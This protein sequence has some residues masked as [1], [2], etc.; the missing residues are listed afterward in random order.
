MGEFELYCRI[1]SDDFKCKDQTVLYERKSGQRATIEGKGIDKYELYRFDAEEGKDF[2]P[3]FNNRHNRAGEALEKLRA[4]CDYIIL[5]SCKGNLYIMLVEMKSGKENASQQLVASH[6]FMEYVKNS[7]LRIKDVN[8]YH[9]FDVN[10]IKEKQL[11]LKKGPKIKNRPTTQP[12]KNTAI[13]W[14][15]VPIILREERL[16]LRKICR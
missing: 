10:N 2:L 14:D 7:A 5:V 9:S 16:P 4:F 11:L 6:V 8:H 1:L 13:D 3:F 15:A 12:A